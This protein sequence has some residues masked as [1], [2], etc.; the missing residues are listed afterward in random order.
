[1][2]EPFN[3]DEPIPT[4]TLLPEAYYYNVG[5]LVAVCSD[6]DTNL[7]FQILRTIIRDSVSRVYAMPLIAGMDVSV[8]LGILRT[9]IVD[10]VGD[11]T[12]IDHCLSRMQ[13]FFDKRN[14]FCHGMAKPAAKK[15]YVSIQ[16]LKFVGAKRTPTEPHVFE[17]KQIKVY[18][19]E[20]RYRSFQLD[21]ELTRAGF[22][23]L[24][25]L[26]ESELIALPDPARDRAPGTGKSPTPPTTEKKS[27][28]RPGGE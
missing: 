6:A 7:G 5:L 27:E 22:A 2:T 26:E 21:E 15:D 12:D 28:P 19:R 20:L 16:E 10:R 23:K 9:V 1:M 24:S 4:E 13:K 3:P 18:A 8:K 17:I 25:L 14:I 11:T